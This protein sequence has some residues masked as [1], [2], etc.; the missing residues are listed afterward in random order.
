MSGLQQL[1]HLVEQSALRH[2]GQQ[3]HQSLQGC[4]GVGFDLEAQSAQL[5]GKAHRSDDAHRV[6]AIPGRRVAN[7]AQQLLFCILHAAVVI[8]H[9]P[10]Q[11]VVVHGID[12]EV[13]PRCGFVLR[14]PHVVAQHTT[15]GVNGVFHARQLRLAAA[16]VALDLLGVSAVQVS[17]KGGHLDHLVFT[18][19]PKHHMHNS[20]AP[21]NDE[22]APEQGLDFFGCGI[23]G[24]IKI[25]GRQAHEQI[26]HC[27]AHDVCRIAPLL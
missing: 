4:S 12:G 18:P 1:E 3:A 9:I 6:F 21:P 17:A 19:T 2:V 26:A 14:S 20:K 16:L 15:A 27:A 7:H 11:R 8:D 13:A 22:G 25:F 24:H 5:G 10:R 23:R